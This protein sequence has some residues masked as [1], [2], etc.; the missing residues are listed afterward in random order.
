MPTEILTASLILSPMTAQTFFWHDYETFGRDPRRDRPAQFAGVRTDADLNEVSE[1]VMAYCQP[2]PDLLP[3]PESCL[4]TGITPQHCAHEGLP[5]H[6]FADEVLR[7]LALPGTLGVGYNSIKFD[8]EV[9]R[10]LLW[11]NLIDPYAREWQ[12]QCGRWDLLNV[13]RCAYAFRPDTLSWPLNADGQ[14]SFRLEH[15]TQ[16]QGIA[17]GQAH[18]ALAD[19]R[20]TLALARVVKQN[21]PRLWAYCLSLTDKHRVLREIGVGRP[22]WHVSG[23]YGV[24]RGCL[25]LVWPLAPHPFHKNEIIVW[26]LTHDPSVLQALSPQDIQARLFVPTAQLPEGVTRLPIKTIHINQSPVVVAAL[27]TLTPTLAQRWGIDVPQ[28]LQHAELLARADIDSVLWRAVFDRTPDT[29]VRRD[30]TEDLYGGLISSD[31]RRALERVR[32]DPSRAT[33]TAFED[34]RLD[35]LAFQYWARRAPSDLIPPEQVRWQD[36]CQ[37]RLGS[38]DDYLARLAEIRLSHPDADPEI[39]EALSQHARQLCVIKKLT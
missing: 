20:A 17:H 12:N 39:L 37:H 27:N 33:H 35:E 16:A 1:P 31:D 23:M 22:F 15:L 21:N 29:S 8:D 34:P 18:D 25:A 9:T 11:R 5:E 24:Q 3:D 26:D 38:L 10:F 14:P 36:H 19:V 30:A 7:Q 4:L 6:Q 32:A 28:C 13:L 2:A